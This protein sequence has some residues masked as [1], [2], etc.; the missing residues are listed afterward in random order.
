M[1]W[2]DFACLGMGPLKCKPEMNRVLIEKFE[3]LR[4]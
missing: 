1:T 3:I 4:D 2:I